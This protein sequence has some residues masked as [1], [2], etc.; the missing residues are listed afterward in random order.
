MAVL[1]NKKR[2]DNAKECSCI[3]ECPTGAFAWNEEKNSIA[4]DNSLCINCRQCVIACEAGAVKVARTDEEYQKIKSEYDEDIMTVEN[5]FQDRF[6][7]SLVDEKY[8]LELKD[9][10]GLINDA[11]KALLIE[12]YNQDE[13]KCLINSVPIS[14]IQKA[15]GIPCSYR[16]INVS[17]LKEL[18]K[19]NLTEL[20]SLMFLSNQKGKIKRYEGFVDAKDKT[21]FLSEV[22]SNFNNI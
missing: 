12:F 18:E 7:A 11:E 3:G 6:G 17:N 21:N 5:L 16:K 9:L 4:V 8:S 2:C 22:R 10:E 19:Y 15:I 1:V 14:E 13:A 20:P